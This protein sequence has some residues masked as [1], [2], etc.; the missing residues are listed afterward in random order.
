MHPFGDFFWLLPIG[1]MALGAFAIWNEYDRQ[2]KALDVLKVYAE[3]GQE[4]PES[5][6]AV[7]NRASAPGGAP[8]AQQRGPWASVA[9]FAVLTLG[10]GAVA[11]WF[12]QGDPQKAWVFIV[13]FAITAFAMAA[14]AAAHL[15]Q[16]LGRSRA[17][18]G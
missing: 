4:P 3:K 11:L 17:N 14:N 1:G 7:L 15:V 13:G 6:L 18:G 16:A 9:F 5:V 2:R 8:P 10:F 12:A